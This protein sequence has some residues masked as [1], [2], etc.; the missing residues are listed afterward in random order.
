VSVFT[1]ARSA[2]APIAA[3]LRRRPSGLF[4]DIDGT[5]SPI[6]AVPQDAVVLPECRSA[7]RRL[8]KR[9]DLV[10]LLSGRPADDAWRMVRVDEALYVGN[11]GVERW[12]RG[13]LLR[14]TEVGRF[15][16]RLGRA[17][18]MLRQALANVP[19]LVFEDKG[20]GFAIHYRREPSAADA[21]IEAA[22]RIAPPR[23]LEV[24]LQSAH[25]EVRAPVSGDKGTAVLDLAK[26]YA[27]RGLVVGG[28]DDV[29]RPALAA[30]RSYARSAA[31][32]SAV[33]I[34]V[35]SALREDADVSVRDPAEMGA[36][37]A[38]LADELDSAA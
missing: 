37:L 24:R 6:V 5:I 9:L 30:A 33:T 8:V 25:V 1:E 34:G 32:A 12:L 35:G 29:D 18:G 17:S 22:R 20:I 21:V 15:H 26:R 10:C 27:L 7:L 23:G 4:L 31:D 11:H 3:A 28:D 19:G 16:A 13:E 14:P 2:F 36:L 38:A